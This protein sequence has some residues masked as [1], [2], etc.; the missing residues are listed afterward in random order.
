MA[1]TQIDQAPTYLIFGA[2]SGIATAVIGELLSER[3]S[4]L[5]LGQF[6]D[7][8]ETDSDGKETAQPQV[9]TFSRGEAVEISNQ[10]TEEHIGDRLVGG[11]LDDGRLKIKT[12]IDYS[13]TELKRVFESINIKQLNIAGVYIFNGILHTDTFMPEKALSQFDADNF[14]A[15]LTANTITPVTII[16]QLLPFLNK[17]Q[18]CKI[19]VL[20]ARIG[21]IGDNEL[22]GWHS[23]RAS[24]AALNMLLKNI[25]IECARRYKNI[26]LISYHPGT[27]D[28]PLSE[29]FQANVPEGKLFER[30][31]S[32]LYFL[33][34]VA[35]QP[36][37]NQL[38][39]VDW[40]GAQIEW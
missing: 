18:P 22:G 10:L 11:S 33:N 29:P 20:S 34:V 40:Q 2:Q 16:Q 9:I 27:T 31:Q 36:F 38:S 8:K 32:A 4:S 25:T 7:G 30:Q 3:V 13:A 21:S 19:A 15:V 17:K 37:N 39:Y 12:I 1:V 5:D 6:S 23:Y 28:T 35:Q 26:K 14:T 24:K